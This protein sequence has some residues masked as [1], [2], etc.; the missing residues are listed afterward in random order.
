MLFAP[1]TLLL[2]L[3]VIAKWFGTYEW[4]YDMT[5]M[6]VL[7]FVLL[8]A[9][10][11]GV[12]A[13][14]YD[15]NISDPASIWFISVYLGY[16]ALLAV[17]ASLYAWADNQW[18]MP[19][20]AV[21]GLPLAVLLLA[22]WCFV[23]GSYTDVYAGAALGVLLAFSVYAGWLVSVWA[24][25]DFYLP[26]AYSAWLELI[27]ISGGV[28]A[29][30]FALAFDQDLFFALSVGFVLLT[31][32]SGGRAVA[33]I[34]AHGAR[35][36]NPKDAPI[37]LGPMVLPAFAFNPVTGDVMSMNTAV[38]DGI[39][40][41][42]TALLWGIFAT[43]FVERIEPGIAIACVIVGGITVALAFAAS[44]TELKLGEVSAYADDELLNRA[45]GSVKSI[46]YKRRRPVQPEAPELVHRDEKVLEDE[47]EQAKRA[48]GAAIREA[49]KA[50]KEAKK[51]R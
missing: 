1:L 21:Y 41:T 33:A 36:G 24:Y 3:A 11:A 16:P 37:L 10:T 29:I 6:A 49:G 45:A 9:G 48:G 12:W 25:Y 47:L 44:D 42:V 18:R 38:L 20:L 14:E 50:I 8:T 43:M 40:A 4:S 5:V 13:G 17:V 28:L 34:V 15:S 19:T 39:S 27:L 7:A 26:E 2:S 23:I 22:V 30:V 35:A 32:R 31:A 51:R 46:F